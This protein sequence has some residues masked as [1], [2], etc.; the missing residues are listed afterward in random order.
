MSRWEAWCFM[1]R[2]Y[3]LL[4]AFLGLTGCIGIVIT[5]ELN[6][7]MTASGLAIVPG[8]Y[9]YLKGRGTAPKWV[10]GACS[11]L[12]LVVFIFDSVV[13]GDFF[14][15]VAHLTIT[16]QAIKSYDLKEPW[17]HLQVYFMSLLQ[18]V[19]ASELSQS[20]VFGIVFV[21][22]LIALVA[23][24][25]F[26]HFAKEG[27][28]EKVKLLMP[29]SLI[30]VAALL[31]TAA[32]F[33]IMPRTAFTFFGKSHAKGM[34]TSGFTDRVDFGSL[35][36]IKLDPSV[37]MRIELERN[38][39]P[40]YYWRGK[41]L[42]YFN[43]K[44]WQSTVGERHRTVK[45]GDEYLLGSYDKES[46]VGQRI[47]LEPIDSDIIFGLS[48]MKAIKVDSFFVSEDNANAVFLSRKAARR[49]SYTAYSIVRSEVPGVR[50][51]RYLQLPSGMEKISHLALDITAKAATDRERAILIERYL[52]R[53]YT[54]SLTVASP[55]KGMN[56]I[57]DF[58]FYSM[59][60]FCEH[61]ATSMVLMLR[62][63]GIPA[64]IVNGF[65]G[66][67]ANEFGGYIIVRQSDAHSWVEALIDNRWTRFDPTPPVP[68]GHLMAI[69]FFLDW[70]KMNWARYV[71]GFQAADQR[72]ILHFLVSPFEFQTFLHLTSAGKLRLLLYLIFLPTV[73]LSTVYLF[74][75]VWGFERMDF[76]S[77]KYVNLK[78]MMS[79]WGFAL[80]SSATP[81]EI[82]N[83]AQGLTVEGQLREFLE[84]YQRHRFGCIQMGPEAR[85]K[86]GQLLKR[87]RKGLKGKFP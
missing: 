62:C 19:I 82:L 72:A 67:E 53:N 71:V 48:E 85:M 30:S 46:A 33:L 26:S 52:K 41:S 4:T 10:I 70:A 74:R 8:Y 27:R 60:G 13:S 28:Q 3:R 6:P 7:V 45:S 81:E 24:M 57:E 9:R 21:V 75:R 44:L 84:L 2:I 64:R 65:Y 5:G 66:G 87:I 31:L 29:V 59:K 78:N 77:R 49:A 42:D 16:F 79:R 32:F 12:T 38:L 54:Y 36:E 58:I 37:V 15:A 83:K 68:A 17:D 86:Y 40:P 35:G 55:Q 1:P 56:P 80:Q 51:S 39:P 61:Y 23:A 34:R 18:M 25:V 47:Y 20:I 14:L 22:F 63:M 43:G 73:L 11:V 50:D 76:V 69:T